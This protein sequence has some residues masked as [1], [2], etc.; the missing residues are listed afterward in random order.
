MARNRLAVSPVLNLTITEA[1]REQARQSRSGG[2]LIADAIK[3]QY[4]HLTGIAVDMATI[5]FSDRERGERY[6]YLTPPSAQH[7]LLNYDAGLPHP[8]EQVMIR[9]AVQ[10]VP[11]IRSH[12]SEAERRAR[13]DE[14]QAMADRGEPMTAV[15][16]RAL[17]V[18][19]K[20]PDRPASRGAAE[21]VIPQRRTNQAPVVVGGTPRVA[22][23]A[24]PNL[25]RGSD[26]HF[27][28]RLANP[29]EVFN[30]AVEAA[31]EQ[32]LA[33]RAGVVE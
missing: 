3:A 29:G 25:L 22:G 16:K 1:N 12:R 10:V 20:T 26:R 27:G 7:M 5:R 33:E 9:S 30:A 13:L 6:I 19:S 17:T 24:H 8:T 2:C 31:V 28:A 23:P 15:E 11:I 32:R 21:V 14:L 4:P 18:M